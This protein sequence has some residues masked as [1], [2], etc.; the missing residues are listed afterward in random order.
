MQLLI[1]LMLKFYLQACQLGK[2]DESGQP[3]GK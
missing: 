3:V 1:V 2:L